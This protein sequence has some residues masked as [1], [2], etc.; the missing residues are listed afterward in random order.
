M[1]PHRVV[2]AGHLEDVG[3]DGMLRL[4]GGLGAISRRKDLLSRSRAYNWLIS[5]SH[6]ANLV[7]VIGIHHLTAQEAQAHERPGAV[8]SYPDRKEGWANEANR[9][10]TKLFLEHLAMAVREADSDFLVVYAPAADDVDLFRR[11]GRVSH[12]EAALISVLGPNRGPL[13]SLTPLLAGSGRPLATLYYDEAQTGRP[14]GNDHWTA[15]G[16]ALVAGY[17]EGPVRDSLSRRLAA[18]GTAQ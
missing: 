5:W 17:L 12:D 8:I 18:R 10:P 4:R 14:S 13:L 6:L 3:P 7:K 15:A 11:T 1:E 9:L 2:E 16:H